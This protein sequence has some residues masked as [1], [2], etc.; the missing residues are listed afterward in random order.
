MS[1]LERLTRKRVAT[2]WLDTDEYF[3]LLKL[4]CESEENER[5]YERILMDE[6]EEQIRARVGR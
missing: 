3:A 1:E 6:R 4:R 2:G 5:E